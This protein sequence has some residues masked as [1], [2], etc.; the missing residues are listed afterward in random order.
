MSGTGAI[1][2]EGFLLRR[3]VAADVAFLAELA[4]HDEVEPFMAA[5]SA[6]APEELLEEVRRSE[7]D[8]SHHGRFVLEVDGEPAGALAFEVANRRSRIAYLHGIMLDPRR[9]GRGLAGRTTRA[10]VRH[11]IL[12]LDYHRVQLEVYGFN[13]RAIALFERAGFVREGVR[14]R[15]YRRHGEWVDGILFGIV[16]EDLDP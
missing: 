11:L 16:R 10:L 9:R 8:P 15:A 13:E 5:V 14:R 6:R 7:E 2:G 1:E 12:E 3:A 4:R